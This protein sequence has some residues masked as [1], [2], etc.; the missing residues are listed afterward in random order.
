MP[1]NARVQRAG[2]SPVAHERG[3]LSWHDIDARALYPNRSRCN[4]MLY[5]ASIGWMMHAVGHFHRPQIKR[6]DALQAPNVI[7]V[8]LRVA[9]TLVVRMYATDRAEVV[10]GRAGV[11]LVKLDRVVTL[12]HA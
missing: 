4:E 11:E 3:T 12:Y 10:L 7:A 1:A 2:A 6:V 5:G 9:A 8:L